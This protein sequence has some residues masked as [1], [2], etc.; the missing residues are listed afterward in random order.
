[1]TGKEYTKVGTYLDTV[2]V[3]G[4]ADQIYR[5]VLMV[6]APSYYEYA[7]KICAGDAYDFNG[8]WIS[9]AGS[10]YDTLVN[11]FGCDSIIKLNLTINQPQN[12]EYEVTICHGT[13]YVFGG[14][15]LSVAGVY[16]DTIKDGNGCDAVVT[17]TL[18][19]AEPLTGT[20]YAEFC[21]EA[22]YYQGKP[23]TAGT[24]EV[25][26]TNEHG[27]DSIVTLI[28]TQTYDVH[29]TLN[30]T[31]C[32]G[33]TYSDENFTVNEPGTYYAETTQLSGCVL[34]H[35]LYF[36]NYPSEMTIDTTVLLSDLA[37]L[38]L[39]VPEEFKADV[40]DFI[41]GISE[42]GEFSDS[43]DGTSPQ[44]CDFTVIINLHV[45][46]PMAIQNIYEE[47]GQKVLKVLYQDHIYIIRQDG[48]YNVSGQKIAAPIQ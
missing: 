3:A 44:G 22:Y 26:V 2:V 47:N 38:E 43:F 28:L 4:Q 30:I 16:T 46:D 25:W 31:V 21:G 24:H 45:K 7:V 5:T 42:S 39:V 8:M 34:Y 9:E 37:V 18:N 35:V 11:V 20:H 32:A 40:K 15:T 17:L 41:E 6:N 14:D 48:W 19:I 12:E 29:D 36:D 33:E 23:Y 27:C 13:T 1:M 10:Y